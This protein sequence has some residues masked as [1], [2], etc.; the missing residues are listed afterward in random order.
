MS[1]VRLPNFVASELRQMQMGV[2]RKCWKLTMRS[3]AQPQQ[4]L[5]S[6]HF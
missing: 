6:V 1:E 3:G 4:P 2:L 5:H